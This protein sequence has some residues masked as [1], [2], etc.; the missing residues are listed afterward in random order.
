MKNLDYLLK[1]A[2]Q[3][4]I[5]L[6]CTIELTKKCNFKCKHCYQCNKNNKEL[7]TEQVKAIIDELYING[8]LLLTI[9]GGEVFARNDFIEIYEYIRKKGML[10]TIFSNISL[11]NNQ[12]IKTLTKYPPTKIYISLY[13]TNENEYYK[14]TECKDMYNKIIKNLEHLKNNSINF[15]LRT[16]ATIYNYESIKR[17]SFLDIAKKFNVDFTYDYFIM[18]KL[19]GKYQE[20]QGRLENQDI[21]KLEIEDKKRVEIWEK[22]CSNYKYKNKDFYCSGGNCNLNIDAYGNASICMIDNTNYNLIELGFK[23]TWI[24]L[25]ERHKELLAIA[26]KHNCNKCEKKSLCRWCP[27]QSYLHNKSYYQ[28]ID[29]MCKITNMRLNHYIKNK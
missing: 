12:I 5:P 1:Y 13:G 23:E 24:K 7:S 9:T 25:N 26:N 10:V 18:N 2:K 21:L 4:S 6:L 8:C 20:S 27:M 11:L 16:M 29:T 15:S 3:E 19:D 14:F 22:M 17:G 28:A